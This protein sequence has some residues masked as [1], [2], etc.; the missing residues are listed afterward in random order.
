MANLDILCVEDEAPIQSLLR[1]QLEQQGH[2]V[3][4]AANIGSAR[5]EIQHKLPDLVLLDWM[6]PDQS[7]VDWLAQLRADRRTA[8]LPI[9]LLTARSADTDKE[10]GLNQGADDYLTKPFSPRELNARIN[11]LLRRLAPQ[12]SQKCIQIGDLTIDPEQHSVS[13]GSLNIECSSSEFKL[14]HFFATH[15]NR[16][17]SRRELLDYVW[18]DHVFVEERTVDVQIGRL[19]KLLEPANLSGS[20]QTVRGSGY[21][22]VIE[23]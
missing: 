15:P 9:I 13:S 8:Q 16:I 23:E 12:K 7:G 18:G 1:F 17:Y 14:L 10:H 3:R 21:R 20:L 2:S 5:Q 19:R 4:V 22:F 6:L 11:A